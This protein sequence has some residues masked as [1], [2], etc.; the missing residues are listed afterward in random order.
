MTKHE[1]ARVRFAPSPTGYLH[2]GGAR[3]ALYNWLFA[4]NNKS[5]FILRIEDTD[6][7]RSTEEAVKAILD[8]MEWLGLN[9]DEGP[10]VGG[11]FGPYFQ[12][13]RLNIY[14]EWA[15]KL[16]KEGKAYHCFCTPEEL[17]EQRKRAAKRKEAPKYDGRCR[18]LSEGQIKEKEAKGLAKVLRFKCPQSGETRVNDMIRGVV[19]FQ[20]ELL[21][22][23]VMV[24]SDGFPTYNFAAI[25]DD[26]LMKIT[27]VIR[28]DDHLSNTPRQILLYRALGLELPEFAHIPM[29]LGKDKARLSKRHGATSV[30]EYKHMGYLP[31]ALLNYIARLG[32]GH[33]DQ[34]IFSIDELIKLFSLEKVNK[35]S[36][37]FDTDKLDWLNAHYI[38]QYEPEQVMEF[39]LPFLKEALPKIS[40]LMKNKEGKDHIQKVVACLHDRLRTF[41]DIVPLSEYFFKDDIEIEKKAS[42]KYLKNPEAK[43]MVTYLKGKLVDVYPFT[44]DN[45]EKV[46]KGMAAE[47]NVKLGTII[48]PTRA[49]LTGRTESPGIYDVVEILGK[50][51]VLKRLSL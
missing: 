5:V 33:G 20:N 51:T 23:F 14:K 17:E 12:T 24:K 15:E 46:F 39:C 32:W 22:D 6:R 45:I 27:H 11:D 35:T 21:D 28:G 38:K 47:L 3:T 48:H 37:V 16:L 40:E 42:D 18:K 30:I 2:V 29:I 7:T 49:L 13:D 41:K 36:A 8:G 50:E 31:E 4:R 1:I 10:D 9:W 25:V 26:H 44:K 19:V 34:E 43:D